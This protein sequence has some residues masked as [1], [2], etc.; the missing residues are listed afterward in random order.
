VAPKLGAQVAAGQLCCAEHT[1]ECLACK[2]GWSVDEYCAA[3]A[4]AH[5]TGCEGRCCGEEKAE[6]MACKVGWSIEEYCAKHEHSHVAGCIKQGGKTCCTTLTAKCLACRD[7]LSTANYCRR[8]EN[9]RVAGCEKQQQ[10]QAPVQAVVP[11][12]PPKSTSTT[13]TVP[14]CCLEHSAKCLA[15]RAKQSLTEFCLD[16]KHAKVPGCGNSC[17]LVEDG[18]VYPGGNLF[19]TKNVASAQDCCTK[20]REVLNCTAWSWGKKPGTQYHGWCYLKNQVEFIRHEDEA[21]VSGLPGR[22]TITFQIKNRHGICLDWEQQLHL[23]EC[24]G[25]STESQQWYMDRKSGIIGTKHGRCID[26]VE[27]LS[28]GGGIHLQPCTANML[29]Q[30][31]SFDGISGLIQHRHGFCMDAP[32]RARAG[33]KVRMWPCDGDSERQLWS[34]WNTQVLGQSATVQAMRLEARTTHTTTSTTI[35]TTTFTTTKLKITKAMSLFCFSLML[36]WGYE[37]GLLH[38]QFVANRS[39]FSCEEFA[40]Y[41]NVSTNASGVMTRVIPINLHCKIGGQ[42]H[43]AL[44]TPIF[45]AVWKKVV[46]DGTFRFHAWT[47][48]ADPDAVFMPMRLRALVGS[49]DRAQEGNGMILNNCKF[50]LHGPLE[51]VSR[52]ALEVYAE[53]SDRCKHPPQEDV[54][55]QACMQ[56]LGVREV[57]QFKLLAEDHCKSKDWDKCQSRHV[58]FHPFKTVSN[59]RRCLANADEVYYY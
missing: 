58:A 56:T 29:S 39:I 47:V 16:Q 43:T 54:Y 32:E 48:K 23:G 59:Y 27:Y 6:C 55:L 37:P 10:E 45:L 24:G 41:S 28:Q 50:G 15:C 33:S 1:A 8:P 12:P 46:D 22:N 42:Y 49:E 30:Q 2:V 20:C 53:G 11:P 13:T 38:S 35:T 14:R 26:S 36:P 3:P 31:W 17:G 19:D 4:H 40:V 9:V 18:Y 5:I 52:R 44:N 21:F 34:L 7:G 57:D 25:P 51:V